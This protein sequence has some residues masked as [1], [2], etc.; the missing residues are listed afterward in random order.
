MDYTD[1]PYFV[2]PMRPEDIDAV[3][4]IERISFPTPW[5]AHA[6]DYELRWNALSHYFVARR[7]EPQV[8]PFKEERQAGLA[9]RVR[10]W[11]TGPV[12]PSPPL[13]GYGG[14]WLMVGEAHISTLAV[15]PDYRRR[16]IGELLL[17]AMLD[18]AAELGAEVMT[19]EVRVSNL[20]AQNLYRK[21][22]FQQVGRRRL[23]YSDRGEDALIMTTERITSASFQNDLQKLKAALKEKLRAAPRIPLHYST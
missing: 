9:S 4:E 15:K 10:R 6:Y 22:A 13:V 3:M 2:E 17:V 23:Y 18:R 11:V 7:R 5:P 1:L 14:F 12:P 16:G 20:A 21:Y 8:V 19:L